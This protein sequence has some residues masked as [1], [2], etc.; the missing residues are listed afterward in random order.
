MGTKFQISNQFID[1]DSIKEYRIENA[2][3]IYRP[4]YLKN[5]TLTNNISH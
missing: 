5:K 2:K 1:I 3:Y 4:Q